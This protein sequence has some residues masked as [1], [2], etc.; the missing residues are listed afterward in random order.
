MDHSGH[1]SSEDRLFM[2]SPRS[3]PG[4]GSFTLTVQGGQVRSVR[5]NT[6]RP[7]HLAQVD[8]LANSMMSMELQVNKKDEKNIRSDCPTKNAQE[9]RERDWKELKREPK[10][11]ARNMK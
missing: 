1:I 2:S 11:L 10:I 9:V 3:Y 8:Q 7:Q 4:Q 5:P 6:I